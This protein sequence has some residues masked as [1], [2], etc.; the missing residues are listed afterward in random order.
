M[1]LEKFQLLVKLLYKFVSDLRLRDCDGCSAVH[2]AARVGG[3]PGIDLLNKCGAELTARAPNTGWSPLHEAAYSGN[4]E[5]TRRLL[6][7]G[8]PGKGLK[9]SFCLV[10]RT[11]GRNFDF[12]YL[13]RI[14]K[15]LNLVDSSSAMPP[16]QNSR[17]ISPNPKSPRCYEFN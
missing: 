3:A 10:L 7:L 13:F 17:R 1:V 15:L 8:V 2:I 6:E 5:T 9:I 16:W 4:Y 12:L 14:F 11:S